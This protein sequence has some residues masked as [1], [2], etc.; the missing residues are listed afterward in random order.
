MA[1][2]YHQHEEDYFLKQDAAKREAIRK[3]LEQQAREAEAHGKLAAALNVSDDA[4]VKRGHE[5][6][7]TA[8][9]ASV[10]HLIPL[11]H[12]AW[13]DGSVSA[14]ERL[15]ILQAAEAH[16][17][18]PGSEASTFLASLL[19]TRPPDA[20]LN[21]VHDLLRALAK[22][23]GSNATTIVELCNDVA[24]ATGG[25]LGLGSK[26]SD[27]ER[28]LIERFEA[29]LKGESSREVKSVVG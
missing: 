28:K 9:T 16:G 2:D 10:I 14:K 22:H 17:A 19:E 26:I 12:V 15:T 21:G 3:R 24:R 27:E 8:E 25:F 6:G 18:K 7:F 1:I 29:S 11:V 4:I 20:W 5:L 23:G 13:A